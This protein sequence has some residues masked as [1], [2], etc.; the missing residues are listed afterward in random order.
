MTTKTTTYYFNLFKS[1]ANNQFYFN[2]RA[3]NNERVLASEGY[4][5][6]QS[7]QNGIS[8]VKIHSPYDSYFIRKTASNGK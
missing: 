7:A 8:S 4:T 5:T 3:G 2:L 1:T 6:K